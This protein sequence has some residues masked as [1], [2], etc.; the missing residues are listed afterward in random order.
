MWASLDL[1]ATQGLGVS[2]S[3]DS[4]EWHFQFR[5]FLF[6]SG[7]QSRLRLRV[8]FPLQDLVLL[9]FRFVAKP[10]LSALSS[11]CR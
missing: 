3:R 5:D 4:F 7:K 11:S 10:H 6:G 9:A 2:W 8:I 1:C